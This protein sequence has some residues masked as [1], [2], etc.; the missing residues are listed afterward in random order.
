MFRKTK[1]NG[2]ETDEVFKYLRSKTP[3]FVDKHQSPNIHSGGHKLGVRIKD[4]QG[5]FCK[6]LVDDKGQVV[7]CLPGEADDPRK[8]EQR[9]EKFLG[10]STK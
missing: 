1:V 10:L 7:D 2:S 5:N 8:L 3:I 9:I 4:I 6:F